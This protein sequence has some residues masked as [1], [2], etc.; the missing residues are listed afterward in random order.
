MKLVISYGGT[1]I[2]AEILNEEADTKILT[3]GELREFIADAH[4][5]DKNTMKVLHRG[6]VLQGDDDLP[7]DKFGFKDGD[8]CI[9]MGGKKAQEDPGF[10]Q[11]VQYEKHNLCHLQKNLDD[12][13]R[14]LTEMEKNYL[15]EAK[16]RELIKKMD[17]RIKCFNEESERHLENLDGLKIIKDDT[18]PPQAQRNREKRK[19]LIGGIQTLLNHNDAFSRRLEEYTKK[20]DGEIVE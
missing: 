15:D 16:Q 8:K 20:L 11:L 9:I 1:T 13:R 10:S 3:L 17:K 6:K 4:K 12:I 19:A 2:P 7:L 5:F 18:T 14:D